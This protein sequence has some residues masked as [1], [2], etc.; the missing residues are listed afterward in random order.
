LPVHILY[1]AEVEPER[2][3]VL[4]S[5]PERMSA[6]SVERVRYRSLDDFERLYA[7]VGPENYGW[8]Q[9]KFHA[10][11]RDIYDDAGVGALRR[12]YQTLAAQEDELTNG[13]LAELLEEQVHPTAAR[14][15]VTWPGQR[16]GVDMPS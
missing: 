13:H 10:A 5:F 12:L 11:A 6:L 16:E 2:L 9:C 3:S 1:I 4:T 7:G 15:M 8:Y 14:V